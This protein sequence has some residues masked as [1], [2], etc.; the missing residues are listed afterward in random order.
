[1][2]ETK[3]ESWDKG[4]RFARKDMRGLIMSRQG[5]SML[6]AASTGNEE[7]DSVDGK[8]EPKQ[9]YLSVENRSKRYLESGF[10]GRA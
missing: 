6:K 9:N 8:D 3:W 1:M 5:R 7:K 10:I 2:G 4:M